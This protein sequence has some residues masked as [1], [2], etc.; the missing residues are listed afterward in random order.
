MH[1]AADQVIVAKIRKLLRLAA[2]EGPEGE[3][4]AA[5]AAELM[6]KH[7]LDV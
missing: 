6:E 5:R 1:A 4:A 3:N 2:T 7:Q